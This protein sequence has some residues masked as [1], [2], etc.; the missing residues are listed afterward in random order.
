LCEKHGSV[1]DRFFVLWGIWGFRLLR[2]ELAQCWQV[3]EEVK[4]LLENVPERDELLAEATWIPGCTAF[5]GGDFPATVQYLEK[6]LTV[7]DE[8]RARAHS[9]RTGQNIGVMFPVHIAMSLWE[10]G[11]PDQALAR[12]EAMMQFARR[13]AHPFSLAM[14][15]YFRRRMCEFCGFEDQVRQSIEEEHTL[16]RQHGFAFWAAHAALASGRQLILQGKINEARAQ[17]EPTWQALQAAGLKCSLEH[18]SSYFAAAYLAV[19][20][21]DDA[22]EWI[23]RGFS[24]A[25]EKDELCL[26][27]ELWR[28][29]GEILLAKTPSNGA[30]AEKCFERAL[31]VARKHQTKS[32]ELRVAMSIFRMKQKLGRAD[33]GRA[34]LAEVYARFT[35]G[36]ATA[37][38][39]QAKALL[40]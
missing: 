6:G 21:P 28:L 20:K 19:G 12:T 7:F 31:A 8:T 24:L 3:A 35:E 27:S 26:E 14:A 36:F 37:D 29:K 4:R 11:F 16:C 33:E 22:A 39:V 13:L 9:L 15:L 18:P 32:R 17:I 30:E 34:L 2:L 25:Q 40:S 5:Y 38:L 10:M 23:E 1:T